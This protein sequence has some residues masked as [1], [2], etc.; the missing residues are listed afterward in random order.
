MASTALLHHDLALAASVAPPP[1]V[2]AALAARDPLRLDLPPTPGMQQAPEVLR[3][4]SA[5]YLSARLEET[6]LIQAADHLVQQRALLRVPATTAAKLED[7]ARRAPQWYPRDQRALLYARLFGLGP[8]AGSDSQGTGSRFEPMLA[9][10]CSAVVA[11]SRRD[12]AY[13]PGMVT[14]SAGSL[15]AAAGLTYGSGVVLAVPRINDQLRRSIDLISDAGIGPLLAT[16]GFWQTLERL[17]EPNVPD[18]RR[19]V[20]CGRHGQRILLWLA[21]ALPSLSGGA[22]EE[23]AVTVDVAVSATAWLAANGLPVRAQEEG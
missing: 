19:L 15:A 8:A 6:G 20:E 16:H 12:L 2:M 11:Q 18:L 1:H 7:M 9:A 13:T 21:A 3:T 14:Y 5:L 17:L 10:L 23:T 4:L 22:P